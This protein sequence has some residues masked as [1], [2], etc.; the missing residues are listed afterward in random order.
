MLPVGRGN[1]P[2]QSTYS[3]PTHLRVPHLISSHLTSPKDIFVEYNWTSR[4]YRPTVRW[5]YVENL[6]SEHMTYKIFPETGR[7]R[8]RMALPLSLFPSNVEVLNRAARLMSDV[9]GPL[10]CCQVTSSFHH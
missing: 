4:D 8:S 6:I 10:A 1:R 2:Y 3:A 5:F 9:N 7:L